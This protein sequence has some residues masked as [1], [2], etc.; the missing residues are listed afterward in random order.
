MKDVILSTR[1][2]LVNVSL[3]IV[4]HVWREKHFEDGLIDLIRLII[5]QQHVHEA[6]AW[7]N[8]TPTNQFWY[9]KLDKTLKETCISLFSRWRSAQVLLS[10]MSLPF[11]D[12]IFCLQIISFF[13][14]EKSIKIK[15]KETSSYT[16][17]VSGIVK[18]NVIEVIN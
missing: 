13:Y 2:V 6:L 8:P 1:D 17:T 11:T 9:V 7:F 5:A 10:K 15:K 14:F 3:D 4:M 18:N 16:I 12:N